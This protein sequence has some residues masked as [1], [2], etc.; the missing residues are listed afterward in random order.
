MA[1]NAGLSLQSLVLEGRLPQNLAKYHASMLNITTIS[2]VS[3]LS[4]LI[5]TEKSNTLNSLQNYIQASHSSTN[6]R[7]R[8]LE[9]ERTKLMHTLSALHQVSESNSS[10]KLLAK[11]VSSRIVSVKKE[12][13]IVM[14]TLNF[15]SDVSTLKHNIALVHEAFSQKNLLYAA[16]KINI[17]RNLPEEVIDSEF[18]RKMVPSSEIPEEPGVLLNQWIQELATAFQEKFQK[19]VKDQK[20]GELTSVFE[21]FPSIGKAELGLDLY[22]KYVCDM[23]AEQ[24]RK[25]MTTVPNKG[26]TFYAQA[27]LHLFRIVSTVINEHSKVIAKY[28]GKEC[29]AH[30]MTKIQKEADMQAGLILD[31]FETNRNVDE[32]VSKD[33]SSQQ[34]FDIVEPSLNDHFALVNEFSAMLQNW[35]MYR[36]F[37]ALKWQEFSGL[38][39]DEKLVVPDPI[40][41]GAFTLKTQNQK[42]LTKFERLVN[43]YLYR[44]FHRSLSLEELPSLND[45]LT[46]P[47]VKQADLGS[48]PV[49]SVLDD[50]T[51]LIRSSLIAVVNIGEGSI[52]MQF[53][54]DLTKFIQ[55]EYLVKFLQSNLKQLQPRLAGNTVLREHN[56]P[57]ESVVASRA[58]SPGV[59]DQGKL[60][61]LRFNFKGAAST[62][63]S[64]IQSNLQAVY[65]DEESVLKLHQYLIYMNTIGVGCEYFDR[66]LVKDLVQDNATLLSDTFPFEDWPKVLSEKIHSVQDTILSQ[67]KK[68]LRWSARVVFEVVLQSRITKIMG[69]IFSSTPED[70]Y[71]CTAENFEDISDIQSFKVMWLELIQPYEKMLYKTCYLELLTVLVENLVNSL[72]TRIWLLQVNELGAIKLDRELSALISLIC[73]DRYSL[74]DKFTNLTQMILVLGLDDDDFDVNSGD[75]KKEILE[76]ITWTLTFQE[77]IDAKNLRID[78]RRH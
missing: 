75:V 1:D 57:S 77:R 73:R 30:I 51:M 70:N 55:S 15:V 47:Y 3:K 23:V 5:H 42:V 38:A 53:L 13:E 54:D 68:L 62:A 33:F 10:A 16:T 12:R 72:S 44:S 50:M 59:A 46:N 25:I 49:S 6:Q 2:Q 22:S 8:K 32:I 64:N 27:L 35:S 36:K 41:K 45:I 21:V 7:V 74:R 67:N 17:I 14:Q 48:Y 4:E 31:T 11:D 61:N 60:S 20:V 78:R 34:K 9:L 58:A 63:F 69:P 40:S 28:Y 26:P 29:M 76:G 37:F 52:L 24:S 39:V 66:L 18:T 65:V 71:L 56:P 43:I 19:A